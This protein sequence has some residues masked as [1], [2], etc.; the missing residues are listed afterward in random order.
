M[1]VSV[2]LITYRKLISDLKSLSLNVSSLRFQAEN[3]LPLNGFTQ[4]KSSPE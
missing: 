3:G 1:F 4:T 2:L